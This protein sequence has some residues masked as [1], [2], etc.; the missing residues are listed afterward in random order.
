MMKSFSLT[1]TAV[2]LSLGA[3]AV[4]AEGCDNFPTV[5]MDISRLAE[6][7]LTSTASAPVDFD[8]VE[9]VND[10]RLEA[11]LAAKAAIAK[12]LNESIDTDQKIEQITKQQS[13]QNSA[14]PQAKQASVERIKTTLKQLHS[15]AQAVLRGVVVLGTCY[16]PGREVR[17]TVGFKPETLQSATNMQN[18]INQSMQ[19]APST[20]AA[21]RQTQGGAT[22]TQS[23][24]PS[25]SMPAQNVPGFSDRSQIDQF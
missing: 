3:T 1:A 10:A 6:N 16:T 18:S 13:S 20:G 4:L 9:A 5:G 24:M 17:V 8:D 25:G 23:N 11:E 21:P 22:A 12:F 14:N 15:N 19:A 7:R 2:L